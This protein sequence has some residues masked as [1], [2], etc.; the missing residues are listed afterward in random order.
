M[1]EIGYTDLISGENS[2]KKYNNG[3]MLAND[4]TVYIN[5]EYSINE[6]DFEGKMIKDI[7]EYR[8]VLAEDGTVYYRYGAVGYANKELVKTSSMPY[9]MVA[10][11]SDG[12]LEVF[13]EV[14]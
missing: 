9:F 12:K 1:Q 11:D 6:D 13:N 4:G 2:I 5:D 7:Y 10:I 8:F 14:E 3:Y